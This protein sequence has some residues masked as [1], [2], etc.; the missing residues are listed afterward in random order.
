MKWIER[1][2][3]D[4]PIDALPFGEEEKILLIDFSRLRVVLPG[5]KTIHD[6]GVLC[7]KERVRKERSPSK[8]GYTIWK[9]NPETLCTERKQAIKQFAKYIYSLHCFGKR[10]TTIFNHIN[11]LK[12]FIQWCDNEY[13]QVFLTIIEA[14]KAY[15]LYSKMLSD[16]IRKNSTHVNSAAIKQ[17]LILNIL[18]AIFDDNCGFLVAG[19]KK[20]RNSRVAENNTIPPSEIIA[21]KAITLYTHLFNG[22]SKFLLHK[23]NYPFQMKL[24]NETVWVFPGHPTFLTQSML[25]NQSELKERLWVWDYVNG[26]ILTYEEIKHHYSRPA[27][28]KE[29]IKNAIQFLKNANSDQYHFARLNLAFL[30]IQSFTMLFIANTGMNIG[31]LSQL[32]WDTNQDFQCNKNIQQGFKTVKHRAGGMNVEFHITNHFLPYFKKYLELRKWVLQGTNAPLFFL[33]DKQKNIIN[34]NASLADKLRRKLKKFDLVLPSARQWRAYKSDW[35]IRTTD[36]A[37]TAL[38]LQNSKETVVQSY[39]A[40]SKISADNEMTAFLN[41]MHLKVIKAKQAPTTEISVGHCLEYQAP[42]TEVSG[43]TI[44]PDCHQAEGCLFCVKYRVHA[45]EDDIRKLCSCRYVINET[46]A[47]AASEMH[48]EKV[49]GVV[50]N[51]IDSLLEFIAS[52]NN[53]LNQTVERIKCEVIEEGKLTI[54]WASKLQILTELTVV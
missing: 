32:A 52:K 5:K 34:V 37:T 21:Q 23:E 35:L 36:I 26:K 48:F 38:L 8:N 47:L 43:S 25:L 20:I 28:A 24:P 15:F 12:H 1:E 10:S 49:F 13:P 50:L 2:T 4:L 27:R 39:M 6:L 51:R 31:P 17:R 45:D 30:A 53:F 41:S 40:G 29:M 54:Y 11:V 14:R 7:F 44:Q 33:R 9:V 18:S 46:R 3:I 19:I 16:E 42:E 22:I